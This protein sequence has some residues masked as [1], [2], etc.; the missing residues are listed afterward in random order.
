MDLGIQMFGC[1][2]IFLEN[3]KKF[4]DCVSKIGYTHIEPCI[5]FGE[6]MHPDAAMK[7]HF[8]TPSEAENYIAQMKCFGLSCN[9]VH[10]FGDI[11]SSIE[12]VTNFLSTN[13]IENV[14]INGLRS[15]L[16]EQFEEF[17]A[18]VQL[19]AN[20]LENVNAK[21]WIHNGFAEVSTKVNGKSFLEAVLEQ[22]NGKLGVQLDAGWAL[23][24]GENPIVLLEKLRPYLCS[25]HFKDIKKEYTNLPFQEVQTCL[26]DGCLDVESIYQFAK[27]CGVSI[28]VDQDY[29]DNDLI[30]DLSR[31]YKLLHSM[32]D[33]V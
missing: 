21:L 5:W 30:N 33:K 8:M 31:S 13:G 15:N 10:A 12:E 22:C 18:K 27:Q 26:G 6:T 3:P 14:A 1:M 17:Q 25:I 29:S 11:V 28:L 24:G 9:S 4:F 2:E 20:H 23:Y 7:F 19:I 32:E 16:L